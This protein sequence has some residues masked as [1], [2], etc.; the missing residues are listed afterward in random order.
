[1][2]K[3]LLVWLLFRLLVRL[4]VRL[5]VMLHIVRFFLVGLP[6]LRKLHI[7]L[8]PVVRVYGDNGTCIF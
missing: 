6:V 8:M 4:H 3:L 1:M 5:L 7:T 2:F